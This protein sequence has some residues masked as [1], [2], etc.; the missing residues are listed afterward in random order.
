MNIMGLHQKNK[1]VHQ[2]LAPQSKGGVSSEFRALEQSKLAEKYEFIP[3]LLDKGH[4]G[5]NLP[6]IL[7]YYRGIKKA[8]PDIVHVR[9]AGVDGL[10]AE[11]AAKLAG[12]AKV[13]LCVH[14]MYSDF[15]YYHPIK[16]W[17]ARYVIE[18]LCFKFADGISCV[19]EECEK[20][21]N[22]QKY[23]KKIVPFVYNRIPHYSDKK[24]LET[25]ESVR[26]QLGIK[27]EDVVGVFCGR[28]SKEKG[29]M[30]LAKALIVNQAQIDESMHFLIVGVGDYLADFKKA[31]ES[32]PKLANNV[33]FLGVMD[34]VE[35]ILSASD[36]F[37][38]PSL[39]ENHSIALLEAMAMELPA[40]TTDVG[41]NKETVKE[42]EFGII[43]PPFDDRALAQAIFKMRD[44]EQ[45]NSFKEQIRA[46]SF[47]EFSNEAVDAQLDVAYQEILQRR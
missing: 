23:R 27:K 28:V 31:I 5:V 35:S 11:I 13:L 38:M 44:N 15:V 42:G 21:E 20:R 40:I 6:D 7:F 30:F 43:I 2:V 17:I 24:R 39:H 36:Y 41:G 4:K 47:S 37:I 9:G 32:Y 33:H 12:Q 14:G 18:P 46:Y 1:V 22:F 8:K 34:D 25:R 16:K 29:L 26:R 3:L 19:Y 10:N 45:R